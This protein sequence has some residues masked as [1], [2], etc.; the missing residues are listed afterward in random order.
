LLAIVVFYFLDY[1]NNIIVLLIGL[2]AIGVIG[3]MFTIPNYFSIKKNTFK[4]ID[5][6][7]FGAGYLILFLLVLLMCFLVTAYFSHKMPIS[8]TKFFVLITILVFCIIPVG[9]GVYYFYK[10]NKYDFLPVKLYKHLSEL[11]RVCIAC[12]LIG[13]VFTQLQFLLNSSSK[14]NLYSA[15]MS[16][17]LA[18][19]YIELARKLT[20]ISDGKRQVKKERKK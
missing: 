4:K 18:S 8:S 14:I 10:F 9:V 5:L 17:L 11:I 1:P 16:V 6:L 15:V 3:A 7:S 12:L 20:V 13:F 19:P 2:F